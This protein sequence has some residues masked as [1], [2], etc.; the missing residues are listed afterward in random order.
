MELTGLGFGD[1]RP[2]SYLG[3][4]PESVVLFRTGLVAATALLVAFAVFVR[5]ARTPGRGFLAAFLVGQAGQVVTAVVP[6]SGPGSLPALHTNAGLVLGASLPLLM[7][8]FASGQAPGR[9]RVAAYRLFWLEA[10]ACVAGVLLSR[11]G[12]AA[13]AEMLPAVAF[14]LWIG[15]V[16]LRSGTPRVTAAVPE[17]AGQA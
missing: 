4:V 8:R 17:G 11:S 13:V 16:T 6:L 1:D 9:W 10:A 5:T 2:I 14:H 15:V 12:L 7:W 3:T